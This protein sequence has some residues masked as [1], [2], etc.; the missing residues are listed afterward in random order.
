MISRTFSLVVAFLLLGVLHQCTDHHNRVHPYR[1]DPNSR[2]VRTSGAIVPIGVLS[3]GRIVFTETAAVTIPGEGVGSGEAI[4]VQGSND[5][6]FTAVITAV[7]GGKTGVATL[8]ESC[9]FAQAVASGSGSGA[10]PLATGNCVVD[11]DFTILG[12]GTLSRAATTVAVTRSAVATFTIASAL[13][14]LGDSVLNLKNG[15]AGLSLTLTSVLIGAAFGAA[16]MLL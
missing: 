12:K 10:Q 2:W 6:E 5:F 3:D 11:E 1:G 7:V 8:G 15:G 16:M 9:S 13:P 4:A 14:T